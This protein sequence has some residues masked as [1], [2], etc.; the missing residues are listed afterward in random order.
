MNILSS[1][2]T[3]YAV[4][5][6]VLVSA[7][8]A[9]IG[10]FLV[11]QRRSL[12]VDMLGHA[13]FPGVIFGFLLAGW[14]RSPF[15]FFFGALVAIAMGYAIF[16]WLARDSRVG[17][18][19]ATAIALSGMFAIGTTMLSRIQ[20]EAQGAQAGLNTFLTGQAA[21][22][23]RIDVYV[24][25][26]L[27]LVV[28]A[29][30][31]KNRTALKVWAFDQ[32]FAQVTGYRS[33]FLEVSLYAIVAISVF[34]AVQAAGVVLASALFVLAPLAALLWVSRF[35]AL[36]W[37][38]VVVAIIGTGIGASWSAVDERM[39]AGAAIITV[40]FL[41]FLTSWFFAPTG[42]FKSFRERRA[43]RKMR[44]GEDLLKSW[45][46]FYESAA[47]PQNFVVSW[48]Q[49]RQRLG[50][51]DA[52]LNVS[53]FKRSLEQWAE[54]RDER[55]FLL[56]REGQEHAVSLVRR[57][58]LW[59]S[60]LVDKMG[61]SPDHVHEN[62]EKVEHLIGDE[63]EFRIESEVAT[64]TDPHGKPIPPKPQRGDT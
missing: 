1:P 32:G 43:A 61:F 28:A 41:I 57:H 56:T 22:I 59:E 26:A 62:A 4:L 29:F 31:F 52:H 24:F 12:L 58:R 3:F 18:D 27:L 54:Y 7:V 2:A 49:A 19:A 5:G 38:S 48:E 50:A 6:S 34:F 53:A 25:A 64:E 10:S 35:E 55:G 15:Y 23:S 45:Y 46:Y 47:M 8:A 33:R 13:V 63:L 17:D 20:Q 9:L 37:L 11:L 30:F 44:L 40:L 21:L 14:Q 16:T 60:Y 36:L 39:P 51:E 42:Y